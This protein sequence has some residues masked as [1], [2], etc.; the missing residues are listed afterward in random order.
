MSMDSVA[1]DDQIANL[2]EVNAVAGYELASA[3]T[4]AENL[5]LIF[6]LL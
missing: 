2:C 4:H 5:V 1:L 3:F 6:K